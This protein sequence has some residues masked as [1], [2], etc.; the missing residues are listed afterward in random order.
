M[1]VEMD[2]FINKTT[3]LSKS[4]QF[5]PMN[6]LSFEYGEEIFRENAENSV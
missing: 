5:Q 1:V 3:R 4:L 2:V 6:A